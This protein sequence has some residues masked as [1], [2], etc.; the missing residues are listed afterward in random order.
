MLYRI[1]SLLILFSSCLPVEEEKTISPD[2]GVSNQNELVNTKKRESNNSINYWEERYKYSSL[3]SEQTLLD[4]EQN[5][6]ASQILKSVAKGEKPPTELFAAPAVPTSPDLGVTFLFDSLSAA[7]GSFASNYLELSFESI[8]DDDELYLPFKKYCLKND[9]SA[10]QYCRY[11]ALIDWG[12][13]ISYSRI[14]NNT[15]GDNYIENVTIENVTVENP[16]SFTTTL[17]KHKFLSGGTGNK[18]IKIHG[19]F[20]GFGNVSHHSDT[21]K[22]KLKGIQINGVIAL[23]D[24]S[25]AFYGLNRVGETFTVPNL[26]S[27][28]NTTA[29]FEGAKFQTLNLS[30]FDLSNVF[31]TASMFKDFSADTVNFHTGSFNNL[32]N[33]SYMFDNAKI[34]NLTTLEKLGEN[35]NIKY[36]NHAFRDAYVGSAGVDLTKWDFDNAITA[37]EMFFG[38]S[39][40]I[41]VDAKSFESL[42]LATRHNNA[43]SLS[44]TTYLTCLNSSPGDLIFNKKCPPPEEDSEAYHRWAYKQRKEA[45]EEETTFTAPTG[46]MELVFLTT[47]KNQQVILPIDDNENV[48]IFWGDGTRTKDLTHTYEGPGIYK[49]TI[50]KLEGTPGIVLDLTKTNT[51]DWRNRIYEV[52]SLGEINTTTFSTFFKKCKNLRYFSLGNN[53]SNISSI[54]DFSSMFE[55]ASSLESADLT[56]LVTANATNLSKMFKNATAL[57]RVVT[58]GW[59]TSSVRDFSSMFEE[60][61]AIERLILD[62]SSTHWDVGDG[63]NFS[64]MFK[65][66]SYLK[67]L[68][69]KNWNIN[70]SLNISNMLQG[71]SNLKILNVRG[72]NEVDSTYLSNMGIASNGS[73]SENPDDTCLSNISISCSTYPESGEFIPQFA[74]YNCYG[75]GPMA[76][77]INVEKE[78]EPIVLPISCSSES[79]SG[80]AYDFTVCFHDTDGANCEDHQFNLSDGENMSGEKASEDGETPGSIS[81]TYSTTGVKIIT[82]DGVLEGWGYLGGH[83]CGD[84]DNDFPVRDRFRDSLIS[85]NMGD[86]RFKTMRNAFCNAKNLSEFISTP[87]IAD[88]SALENIYSIFRYTDLTELDLNHWDTSSLLYMNAA[89]DG[90]EDL[91]QLNISRWNVSNTIAFE[92][93]FRNLSSLTTL[94]LSRWKTG[95]ITDDRLKGAFQ[96][97]TNIEELKLSGFNVSLVDEFNN[98]FKGC[99]NLTT[100]DFSGWNFKKSGDLDLTSM[101]EGTQSLTNFSAPNWDGINPSH[102]EN[103]FKSSG[104]RNLDLSSWDVDGVENF[105]SAF[106]GTSMTSLNLEGWELTKTSNNVDATDMFKGATINDLNISNWNTSGLDKMSG[107]FE[108]FETTNLNLSHFN[109]SSIS[110]GNAKRVFKDSVISGTL[111]LNNFNFNSSLIEEIEYDMITNYSLEQFWFDARIT[112]LSVLNWSPYP[113]YAQA[114]GPVYRTIWGDDDTNNIPTVICNTDR[115]VNSGI[116]YFFT[117]IC[118]PPQVYNIGNY[119][120]GGALG[121]S[122]GRAFGQ[123]DPNEIVTA[124]KIGADFISEAAKAPVHE[125]NPERLQKFE[126]IINPPSP[127]G[128]VDGGMQP[129]GNNGP[130]IIVDQTIDISLDEEMYQVNFLAGEPAQPKTINIVH[131]DATG[132]METIDMNIYGQVGSIS[133]GSETASMITSVSGL[134]NGGMT[135]ITQTFKGMDNLESVDFGGMNFEGMQYQGAMEG[136]GAPGMTANFDNVTASDQNVFNNL[137]EGNTAITS[138]TGSNLNFSGMRSVDGMFSGVSSLN[139]A[140]FD[141]VNIANANGLDGMLRDSSFSSFTMNNATATLAATDA[142]FQA[143]AD[144]LTSITMNNLDAPNLTSI[145]GIMNNS[146]SLTSIDLSGAGTNL[147]SV[148]SLSGAASSSLSLTSINLNS[149]NLSS[150]TDVSGMTNNL[151]DSTEV[152]MIGTDFSSMTTEG[153]TSVGTSTFLMDSSTLLSTGTLTTETFDSSFSTYN[154]DYSTNFNF[155]P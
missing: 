39:K 119:A 29:M 53:F 2:N 139:T 15:G 68:N 37:S 115:D 114:A 48:E 40:S 100:L 102:L 69:L 147:S 145:T 135:D 8:V 141:G 12:D 34:T 13:G 86:I 71:L 112:T 123:L 113:D 130:I 136:V 22:T 94:D 28:Y 89:F 129:S 118:T 35:N 52:H 106:E 108:G 88:T 127:V 17:L 26:L 122:V 42:D 72:W 79:E 16:D 85:F 4:K 116:R 32:N 95:V 78:G 6:K 54:T 18:I 75:P 59:D 149:A 5:I 132:T 61:S 11:N 62:K 133:F 155:M 23:G 45:E 21:Y 93:A 46:N 90:A 66:T 9:G 14:S 110:L 82:I 58:E 19:I 107:M 10:F 80:C 70:L 36:F 47:Q 87:G 117:R 105:T 91:T 3:E 128:P 143:G 49:A 151:S 120:R 103:T 137:F 31:S 38:F 109:V 7:T 96:G 152:S 57:S 101:F 50:M 138:V 1:L 150:V 111:N 33:I 63:T 126:V 121:G 44:Q 98:L 144:N 124:E 148:T 154:M 84:G 64:N 43:F 74:G 76:L 140:S 146:L 81:H 104:I 20:E 83:S 60:A 134:A 24:L 153:F 65:N 125:V 67:E 73:C 30:S 99:S 55:E 56:G 51:N 41:T 77:K 131:Y 27:V 97:M 92:S 25:Y 142:N